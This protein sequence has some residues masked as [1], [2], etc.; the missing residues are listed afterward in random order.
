MLETVDAVILTG[1]NEMKRLGE[2]T[3]K[4]SF[5]R[6]IMTKWSGT[7][8]STDEVAGSA[9]YHCHFLVHFGKVRTSLSREM[10]EKKRESKRKGRVNQVVF[11]IGAL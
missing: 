2:L 7:S 9:A 6:I 1:S 8:H 4:E 5:P 10:I 3:R 11:Y